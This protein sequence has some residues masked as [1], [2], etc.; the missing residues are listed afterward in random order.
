MFRHGCGRKPEAAI[1][2]PVGSCRQHV[3]HDQPSLNVGGRCRPALLFCP[4]RRGSGEYDMIAAGVW[5]GLGPERRMV[6]HGRA[7]MTSHGVAAAEQ[8]ALQPQPRHR[9]GAAKVAGTGDREGTH[10]GKVT[11]RLSAKMAFTSYDCMRYQSQCQFVHSSYG[12]VGRVM[13]KAEGPTTGDWIALHWLLLPL[14][15][16]AVCRPSGDDNR[17]VTDEPIGPQAAGPR[18]ASCR[19]ALL[20]AALFLLERARRMRSDLQHGD[21]RAAQRAAVKGARMRAAAA[22]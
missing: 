5:G 18:Q 6:A 11:C 3:R 16:R 4:I 10:Q 8:A 9:R 17:S 14:L 21:C 2:Q 22:G 12:N 1:K 15:V 19:L 7:G 13:A 20:P